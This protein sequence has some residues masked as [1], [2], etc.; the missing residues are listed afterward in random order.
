ML[1]DNLQATRALVSQALR[2]EVKGF[3]YFSS[4]S[5][6]GDISSSVVNEDTPSINP[7]AYGLTKLLGERLLTDV[8]NQLPHF[9]YDF[10]P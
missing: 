2:T 10:L 4:L 8:A 5:T 9:Q 3:V 6:L 1:I 7:D